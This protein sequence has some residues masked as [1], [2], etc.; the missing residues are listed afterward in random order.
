MSCRKCICIANRYS[1]SISA[2]RNMLRLSDL[3]SYRFFRL[4]RLLLTCIMIRASGLRRTNIPISSLKIKFNC[5]PRIHCSLR[6][7]TASYVLIP[8]CFLKLITSTCLKTWNPLPI[9]NR[10]PDNTADMALF[11]YGRRG[12]AYNRS[13]SNY[14]SLVI[15][16]WEEPSTGI[17]GITRSHGDLIDSPTDRRRTPYRIARIAAAVAVPIGQNPSKQL[18]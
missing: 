10:L 13:G 14:R 5:L 2:T 15:S 4:Q 11:A 9:R 18:G 17:T 6:C 7:I 12:F 8:F 3:I 1:F 16:I